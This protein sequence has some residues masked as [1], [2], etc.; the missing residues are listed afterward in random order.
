MQGGALLR[1]NG[2]RRVGT[3]R[4]LTYNRSQSSKC[5]AVGAASQEIPTMPWSNQGGGPW[6]SGGGGK[7]PWGSGQQPSGGG[8]SPPDL[9]ELLRRSQDKLRTVLPG[10]NLGGKGLSLIL[11]AAIVIWGFSGF[12]RVDPDELGVVLRFGKYVRDGKP[13][14]NYHL[15][16]PIE[17]ALTQK[18][19]RVN[20]IDIG[21]RLVE[22]RR[23]QTVR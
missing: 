15:P 19:T 20:R 23:G 4:G 18:V 12:F 1:R 11:L 21:M 13:G 16:Y 22:E 2:A 8:S 14:L 5:P 7:G 10:G 3:G 9:E 6:G 17:S